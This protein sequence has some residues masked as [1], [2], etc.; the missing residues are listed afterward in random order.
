MSKSVFKTVALFFVFCSLLVFNTAAIS[1]DDATAAGA[2][3]TQVK[4]YTR[5]DGTVV[6]GHTR[7]SKAA[8]APET[9][10]VKGYTRKDGTVVK[11]YTRK[12]SS[13]SATPAATSK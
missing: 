11:G 7:S 8:K 1:K 2:S 10:E 4:S 13:K 5:K 9:T 6:K 12:K 3:K